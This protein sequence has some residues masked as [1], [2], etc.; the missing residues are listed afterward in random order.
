[1]FN[2]LHY[3]PGFGA[4]WIGVYSIFVCIGE[5]V[6]FMFVFDVLLV[7][8]IRIVRDDA[9]YYCSFEGPMYGF[10]YNKFED[11]GDRFR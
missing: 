10:Y 3:G 8:N 4:G 1:M 2:I 7:G 11:L 9:A 5:C 6:V